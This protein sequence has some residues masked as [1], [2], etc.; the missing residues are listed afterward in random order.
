[1]VSETPGLTI[2]GLAEQAGVPVRTIRFYIA[3]DLL[4]GPRGRGMAARYGEEHL[5][6]LRLIRRLVDQ[7]VPL[8]E[9]RARLNR[10]SLDDVRSLLAEEDRRTAELRLAEAAPSPK[11]YVSALLE[12]A[13]ARH[14]PKPMAAP[15]AASAAA[16]ARAP[17]DPVELSEASE[18]SG[19]LAPSTPAAAG[20]RPQPSSS[21]P[22]RSAAVPD[23]LAPA[24]PLASQ[25][26]EPGEAWQRWEL[27]PGVELHVR[28]DAERRHRR[29]V[30]RLLRIARASRDPATE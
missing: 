15:P 26:G 5:L 17:A 16:P 1:M 21:G 4:A 24:R 18:R 6:R 14:A 7:R 13:Q 23:P 28:A 29:L 30:E 12:R 11:D 3:E 27:A 20:G 2:E 9:Q 8:A 19:A 25:T 10:L 22:A